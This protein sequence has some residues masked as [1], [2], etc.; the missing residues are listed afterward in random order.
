RTRAILRLYYADGHG[1][2][3]IG[4]IYNVHASTVSRWLDKARGDILAQTRADLIERLHTPAS[5]IDSLLGH[6]ASLEIS[7]E[8]LLRS[9]EP[10]R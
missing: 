3:D 8:G 10:A 2:E 1:V 4:R 6:A 5:Q 7:L 9:V